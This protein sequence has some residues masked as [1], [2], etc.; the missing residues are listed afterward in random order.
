M[1]RR[2]QKN[3]ILKGYFITYC[4]V[5]F[6]PLVIC[7]IYY[8][9]ILGLIKADD[10]RLTRESLSYASEQV[11]ETILEFYRI[12]T[13]LQENQ[14]VQE[15]KKIETVYESGNAYQ[16]IQL[17]DSLPRL[18]F[19]NDMTIQYYLFFQKS[20]MVINKEKVYSYND[21][22][23]IYQ[24]EKCFTTYEDWYHFINEE[25][26]VTGIVKETVIDQTTL[27]A[28]DMLIYTQYLSFHNRKDYSIIRAYMEEEDLKSLM[29]EIE[30]E[31][32][33]FI[34][35]SR[36]DELYSSSNDINTRKLSE[37][38]EKREQAEDGMFVSAITYGGKEYIAF[39]QESKVTGLKY[40]VLHPKLE[41]EQRVFDNTVFMLIL[42]LTAVVV[43]IILSYKMSI[44][45]AVPINNILE[46]I[47][48]ETND[49]QNSSSD[50]LTN[51]N[52]IFAH[53]ISKNGDLMDMLDAQRDYT[54]KAFFSRL[55]Y[56]QLISD[57]ELSRMTQYINPSE[58]KGA[59]CVL[60]I[61]LDLYV[62]KEEKVSAID[63][64]FLISLEEAI[65]RGMPDTLYTSIGNNQIAVLISGPAKESA[66][67]QQK[68]E[69]LAG[70]I[71]EYM[72][73]NI[74]RDMNIYGGNVVMSILSLQ[75]S[76][77]N[78][79]FM[80]CKGMDRR[81]DAIIWYINRTEN[82]P[83]Y[84]PSNMGVRLTQ[85][86]TTGNSEELHNI[87]EDIAKKYIF[88]NHL[89]GYLQNMMLNDLQ[90]ILY[91]IIGQ[92]GVDNDTYYKFYNELEKNFN[93]PPLTQLSETIKLYNKVCIYV[94][95]QRESRDVESMIKK[96][97]DYVE[98]NYSDKQISLAEVAGMF[99]I[100][101]SYL[102]LMFKKHLG[103]NFSLYLE[104]VRIE[105]AKNLLEKTR[106][107]ISDIAQ[108][109]GYSSI[110]TFS[111]AFKRVAGM[112]ASDY[113][114]RFLRS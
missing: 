33:Q 39:R 31:G 13:V 61:C 105:K 16:A 5:L 9:R 50:R 94:G 93:A 51:L 109:T 114:R 82:I 18:F 24:H 17:Q 112:S 111:R 103:E 40:Y 77:N 106:L 21:F 107:S 10:I 37:K 60:L 2:V 79:D 54:K 46:Q 97:V 49:Y 88:E 85:C 4:I 70:E 64:T 27:K 34:T 73:E 58:E 20:Q 78:A 98:T 89:T 14:K 71:K 87:L 95:Q 15:F 74:R 59:Y 42:F 84:P 45:S 48:K 11:D 44:K 92:I 101:E 6:I 75:D 66:Q 1:I 86:V 110:N 108:Q 29:P 7:S 90:A 67:I 35:N 12:G 62:D 26:P 55:I 8:I 68:A 69:R 102:S 80:L 41:I 72:P 43:G 104:K 91:R 65:K 25:E 53:L 57:E 38:I 32:I 83:D 36:G 23:H 113:R 99:H 63:E 30:E 28:K 19:A 56:G 96:I 22:Y 81:C 100:S 76:Y 47:Y 52:R 3:N